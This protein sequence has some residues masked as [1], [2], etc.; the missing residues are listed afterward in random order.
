[1]IKHSKTMKNVNLLLKDR[2]KQIEYIF[3]H[4]NCIQLCIR[5]ILSQIF[6]VILPC[7]K[8]LYILLL[9]TKTK[10]ANTTK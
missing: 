7:E 4:E 5:L 6:I 3:W 1:M 8:G 2:S 9:T 10:V